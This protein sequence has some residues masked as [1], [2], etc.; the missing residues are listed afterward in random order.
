[1]LGYWYPVPTKIMK[2]QINKNGKRFRNV[3]M[4]PLFASLLFCSIASAQ[5][6]LET[7]IRLKIED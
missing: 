2:A 4:M 6:R 1:M 7:P 3:L 5:A